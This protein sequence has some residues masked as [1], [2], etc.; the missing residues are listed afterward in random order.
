MA[1]ARRSGDARQSVRERGFTLDI[2]GFSIALSS[3][4]GRSA[5]RRRRA[6]RESSSRTPDAGAA[7]VRDRRTRWGEPREP[8]GAPLFDSG[9]GLWRMYRGAVGPAVRLHVAAA[10]PAPLPGRDVQ[11]RLHRGARSRCGAR[12]SPSGCRS[13][14]CTIRS[15]RCSWCTCSRAGGASSI[16]GAGVVDADGRGLLFAGH[17]GA[18]KTTLSSCGSPSPA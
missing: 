13:I 8:A 18:G 15:T 17:S 5:H 1:T 12:P 16:H 6:R 9:K 3:A 10:R 14:R 7:A 11:P 2:A 4:D